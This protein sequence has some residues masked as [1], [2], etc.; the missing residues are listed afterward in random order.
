ELFKAVAC[1]SCHQ[2]RGEGAKIGPDL[3]VVRQKLTDG[4]LDRLRI[5]TEM[6]EPSKVID[7]KFRTQIIVDDNGKPYSGVVVFEDDKLVRIMSNPLAENAK[8]IDIPKG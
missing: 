6:L 3:T 2:M 4:K 1:A 5:L 7:E 8:P